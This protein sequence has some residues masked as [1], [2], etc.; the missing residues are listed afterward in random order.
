ML[1]IE[2]FIL[3]NPIDLLKINC[4]LIKIKTIPANRLCN[5]IMGDLR[6]WVS[7]LDKQL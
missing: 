7:D 5:L 2:I 1:C 3:D 4:L 6:P